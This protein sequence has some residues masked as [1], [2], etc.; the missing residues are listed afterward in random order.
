MTYRE[1]AGRAAPPLDAP[2]VEP[3]TEVRIVVQENGWSVKYPIESYPQTRVRLFV[4]A[5]ADAMM[6]FIREQL[7]ATP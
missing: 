4:A 6:D 7:G 3:E 2:K 5:D 1:S